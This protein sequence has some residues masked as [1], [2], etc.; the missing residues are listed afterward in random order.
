MKSS[1]PLGTELLISAFFAKVDN[2]D[3]QYQQKVAQKVTKEAVAFL[4]YELDLNNA[5]NKRLIE[6]CVQKKIF[7]DNSQQSVVFTLLMYG[8]ELQEFQARNSESN[9]T[10]NLVFQDSFRPDPRSVRYF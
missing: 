4:F 6:M 3:D 9:Q 7:A 10:E 2:F 8:K 5:L 1:L